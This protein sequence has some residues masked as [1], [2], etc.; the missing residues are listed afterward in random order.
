MAVYG[1]KEYWEDAR[2]RAKIVLDS[3]MCTGF[4]ANVPY[5]KAYDYCKI[6]VE[7]YEDYVNAVK[8]IEDLEV[9]NECESDA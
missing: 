9:T 2:E 1:T 7:H 6:L 5:K 3:L 8:H 4:G